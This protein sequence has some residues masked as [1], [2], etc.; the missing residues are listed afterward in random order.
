[1]CSPLPGMAGNYKNCAASSGCP[2][3]LIWPPCGGS[4]LLCG[5]AVTAYGRQVWY[6]LL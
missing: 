5:A 3:S 1:M 6:G 2:T 4:G